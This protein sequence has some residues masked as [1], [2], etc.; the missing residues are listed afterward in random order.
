MALAAVPFPPWMNVVLDPMLG[1]LLVRVS[2]GGAEQR[3]TAPD[4]M[5]RDELIEHAAGIYKE[6]RTAADVAA[7]LTQGLQ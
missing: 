3:F 4:W 2:F 6:L 7:K 1:D 5:H